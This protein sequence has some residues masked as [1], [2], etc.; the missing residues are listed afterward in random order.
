MSSIVL[1]AF[2]T[3]IVQGCHMGSRMAA[4]LFA[5][6]LG[7]GPLLIGVLISFYSVFPLLLAV[8]C[9]RLTDRFGSRWPM[10]AGAVVLALGL[11]VP[12]LLPRLAILYL[13][14]A[15]IGIGFVFFNVAAQNLAGA[16]GT[17]EQRTRN[18][19]TLG[20]G[21]SAGHMA[22]PLVAGYAIDYRGFTFAYLCIAVLALIAVSVLV[23]SR[24]LDVAPGSAGQPRGSAIE[25][26]RNPALRR[27]IVVSGL[28]VTGMDLYTFYV[29]IYGHAI[30]LPAST[31]GTILGMF[32]AA[33]FAVR[34]V[35][36]LITRRFGVESVLAAAMAAG[37]AFFLAFPLVTFVPALLAL[38]FGIGLAIGCGQPLTLN[39]AY[40]RSPPGRSGEVTGLR[41]TVNNVT[42]IIVPL[43]AGVLGAALGVAPVFWANAAI[44]AASGYLSH[45]DA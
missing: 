36:P 30:G 20:L 28:V 31:I 6:D 41:L 34:V 5:I 32:A 19:A 43:A 39:I 12:Y 3:L 11:I 24:S 29:P 35:V 10:L 45:R 18:F 2:I 40:N 17:P 14:A 42:H 4:S 9:G 13:S 21:Y 27:A 8:Y 22:G 44:L 25:L 7:A 37:A 16:L 1:L 23:R 15:L 26:M 38:S 33:T